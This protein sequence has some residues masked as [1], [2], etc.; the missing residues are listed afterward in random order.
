MISLLQR[1]SAMKHPTNP[2]CK[3]TVKEYIYGFYYR[4]HID[5]YYSMKPRWK[6]YY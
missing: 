6:G 2:K 1:R 3:I 4:S 5:L